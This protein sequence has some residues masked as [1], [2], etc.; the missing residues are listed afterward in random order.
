MVNFVFQWDALQWPLTWNR[1]RVWWSPRGRKWPPTPGRTERVAA[2]CWAGPRRGG[3]VTR[4]DPA[5]LHSYH[6]H[7]ASLPARGGGGVCCYA[8]E[9]RDIQWISSCVQEGFHVQ[10][11]R[12][13]KI[14]KNTPLDHHTEMGAGAKASEVSPDLLCVCA[15]VSHKARWQGRMRK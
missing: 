4:M 14:N 13:K 1:R 9:C 5:L 10:A 2:V 15:C 7:L 6:C 12:R 8:R 3:G 11:R